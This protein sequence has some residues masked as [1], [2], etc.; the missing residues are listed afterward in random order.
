MTLY[1]VRNQETNEQCQCEWYRRI[2]SFLIV[3]FFS[4]FLLGKV[5]H[6]SVLCHLYFN[7]SMLL[8][9]CTSF[10]RR[11]EQTI[12]AGRVITASAIELMVSHN[13]THSRQNYTVKMLICSAKENIFTGT[14]SYLSSSAW[15][16]LNS[17][18]VTKLL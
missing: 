11:K 6:Y 12:T 18:Q 2:C 17:A 10:K 15:I 5:F 16:G 3:F 8:F 4:Y 14:C 7:S 9:S 1:S 13:W